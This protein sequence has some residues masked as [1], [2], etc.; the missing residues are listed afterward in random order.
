MGA[1]GIINQRAVVL[2]PAVTDPSF[3][4]YLTPINQQKVEVIKTKGALA[5]TE[6]DV[7]FMSEML[8]T[9]SC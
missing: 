2:I 8:Y 5:C 7:Q 9:V 3:Y 6:Q 4:D 1:G